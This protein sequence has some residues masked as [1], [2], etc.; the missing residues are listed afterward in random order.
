MPLSQLLQLNGELPE[1]FPLHDRRLH[2]LACRKKACSRKAGSIRALRA[3]RHRAPTVPPESQ[4]VPAPAKPN[5]NL[6]NDIFGGRLIPTTAAANPFANPFTKSPSVSTAPST[7]V[8]TTKTETLSF[9]AAAKPASKPPSRPTLEPWPSEG[10]NTNEFPKL[11]L[12]AAYEDLYELSKPD[13][14][15]STRRIS[16]LEEENDNKAETSSG[17][18]EED[19]EVFES[20]IDKVFQRFAD[21]IAQNPE[22]VLRYEF[23][24]VPVLYSATDDIGKIFYHDVHPRMSA[25][26]KGIPGCSNCGKAR[27]FELQLT[28]HLIFELEKDEA[29]LDGMEW[30]SII[31][32]VC[33]ADCQANGIGAD[34]VGYLEE[35]VGVQWEELKK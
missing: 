19:A 7:T 32:G 9:A 15:A 31:V 29:G 28:P 4:Q 24:G 5:F 33:E 30:G 34:E 27:A 21:R 8:S 2:V 17:A 20:S 25:A 23:R 18:K 12:D 35:W 16:T 1:Q 14:S 6:G 22:Q 10:V 26:R 13:P 11:Y 3:T